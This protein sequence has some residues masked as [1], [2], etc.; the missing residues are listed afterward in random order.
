MGGVTY[1]P[2]TGPTRTCRAA[3]VGFTAN[4]LGFGPRHACTIT[5]GD[6]S[7][8][9]STSR[10]AGGAVY[11]HVPLAVPGTRG[12]FGPNTCRAS[13]SVKYLQ[14]AGTGVKPLAA[15]ASADSSSSRSAMAAVATAAARPPHRPTTTHGATPCCTGSASPDRRRTGIMRACPLP[16]DSQSA[17]GRPAF[18]PVRGE[19]SLRSCSWLGLFSSDAATSHSARAASG[20]NRPVAKRLRHPRRPRQRP[21]HRRHRQQTSRRAAARSSRSSGE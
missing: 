11:R 12:A 8:V 15:D 6:V 16:T 3:G 5:P 7:G 2:E 20:P 21:H 19:T 14:T 9:P 13:E 4:R 17:K 18:G 10:V 1:H